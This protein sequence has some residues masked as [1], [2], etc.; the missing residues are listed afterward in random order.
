[1]SGDSVDPRGATGG[2]GC[3]SPSVEVHCDTAGPITVS[4]RLDP[5][6]N[7]GVQDRP[8]RVHSMNWKDSKT[9]EVSQVPTVSESIS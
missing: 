9:T 8:T 1:M 5:S 2:D 6:N 4:I 7:R 3:P